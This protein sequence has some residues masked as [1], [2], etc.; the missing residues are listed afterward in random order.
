MN[1]TL[2]YILRKAFKLNIALEEPCR[3]HFF[4]KE[5]VKNCPIC[6]W[7]SKFTKDKV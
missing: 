5:E 6:G 2:R 1:R 7:S 4:G 3:K